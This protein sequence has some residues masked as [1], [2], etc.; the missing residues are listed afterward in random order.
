MRQKSIG[1]YLKEL[2][3]AKGL[4]QKDLA[5]KSLYRT[6]LFGSGNVESTVQ[7]IQPYRY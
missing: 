1:L 6:V 2:R 4:T 3:V 7:S 5:E